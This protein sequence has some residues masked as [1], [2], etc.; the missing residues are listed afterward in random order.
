MGLSSMFPK[1][2]SFL[3]FNFHSGHADHLIFTFPFAQIASPIWNT[4]HFPYVTPNS[5]GR[6]IL[7]NIFKFNN[8]I[9]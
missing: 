6:E 3:K 1:N 4:F 9:F 5:Q 8:T 7:I 2:Y